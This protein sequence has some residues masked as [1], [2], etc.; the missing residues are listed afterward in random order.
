MIF[1]QIPSTHDQFS[2]MLIQFEVSLYM[3]I[4]V[5]PTNNILLQHMVK[6]YSVTS[7]NIKNVTGEHI[8]LTIV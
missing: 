6:K 5:S 2:P 8:I 3:Q 4:S 7:Y 1:G